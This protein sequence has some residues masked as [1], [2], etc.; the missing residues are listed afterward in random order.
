MSPLR[1]GRRSSGAGFVTTRA[2]YGP[3]LPACNVSTVE[4][5]PLRRLAHG[6][7]PGPD[8]ICFYSI[9][10]RGH[11]NPRYE[12]LLPRLR[13]LDRYLLTLSDRRVLRGA[14]FRAVRAVKGVRDPFVLRLASRK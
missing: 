8:R 12:E 3:H 4:R 10:F 13:R 14:E 6:P 9:W 5:L 11:N 7:A 1:T 2:C